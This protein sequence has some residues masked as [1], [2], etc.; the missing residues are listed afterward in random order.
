MSLPTP[1][2][3]HDGQ[4]IYHADAQA[5]LPFLPDHSF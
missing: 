5:I 3:E 4:T 1:Y 2:Y